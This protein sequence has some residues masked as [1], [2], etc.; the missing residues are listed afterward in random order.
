MRKRF[1]EVVSDLVLTNEQLVL[2]LGDIGVYGFRNLMSQAP[3]RALN[4][5]I[6]EQA[7]T[8]F[9]AG[10]A[11][12]GRIPILHSI[13]PFLI[14]RPYE[15][16]KVDF[17]YQNLGGKFVSVGGSF[18]YSRLGATHHSPADISL[19]LGIPEFKIFL[20]SNSDELESFLR[21][22]LTSKSLSYFRL[23][24]DE[25]K[26]NLNF[27]KF[28]Q[29]DNKSQNLIIAFGISVEL[30]LAVANELST[31]LIYINQLSPNFNAQVLE[32][33]IQRE[34]RNIVLIQP[35]YEGSTSFLFQK[36]WGG[37]NILD[38]G[39]PRQFIRSYGN[40]DEI[41]KELGLDL[42]SVRNKV[43]EFIS[44]PERP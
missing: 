7:M 40:R 14:E 24:E 42:T 26:H 41:S 38:I 17:G 28:P 22:D 25:V 32:H 20:P 15:Q 30:G 31:N 27:S 21:G 4:M 19:V 6:M 39:V 9:A 11:L 18:D 8:S 43:A 2:L 34:Y 44:D 13:T 5:G 3:R 12:E 37:A 36:A 10:L 1:Q 16:I 35:F 23:S 29:V 33:L